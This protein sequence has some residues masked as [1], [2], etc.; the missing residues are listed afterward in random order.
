LES[1]EVATR[2]KALR[3]LASALATPGV[4]HATTSGADVE[5]R[6]RAAHGIAAEVEA[7]LYEQFGGTN[8]KYRAQGE[9]TLAGEGWNDTF[10][11]ATTRPSPAH[12]Y[13]WCVVRVLL[14]L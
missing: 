14:V 9:A 12:F 10:A 4:G 2:R 13:L 6:K 7:E 3:K 8:K 11:Y 1:A 5:E